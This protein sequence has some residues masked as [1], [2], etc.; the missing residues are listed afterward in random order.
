MRVHAIV[1]VHTKRNVGY[2][3]DDIGIAL[4]AAA[5]QTSASALVLITD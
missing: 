3:T 1:I 2:L 4:A 5:I